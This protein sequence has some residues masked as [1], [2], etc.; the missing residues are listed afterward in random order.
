MLRS[1]SRVLLAIGVTA[2]I[3]SGT[4]VANASEFAVFIIAGQSNAVGY[5]SSADELPLEFQSPQTDILFWYEEGP[6]EAV[7]N[8]SL[9]IRSNGFV[10]LHYQTDSTGATFGGAIQ[11]FGAEISF[12]R[13]LADVLDDFPLIVDSIAIVKF[14]FNTASLAVDW[15]PDS[16]GSLYHQMI[17]Q[18]DL[19][20]AELQSRGHTAEIRGIWWMQGES[21]AQDSTHAT[22]YADNLNRLVCGLRWHSLREQMVA[23]VGRIPD[24]QS[25]SCCY[26][27]PHNQVVRSAQAGIEDSTTCAYW[28]N[29]DTL[30]LNSDS[31]HFTASSQLALGVE[32]ASAMEMCAFGF[33]DCFPCY[34][35]DVNDNWHLDV[36]DVVAAVNVAFR[37]QTSP[38]CWGYTLWPLTDHNC[39]GTTDVTDV[40]RT[41]NVA[42]RGMPWDPCNPCDCYP[43]P[44]NC[45]EVCKRNLP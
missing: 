15:H 31:V 41:I 35:G 28:V 12:G 4:S 2:C 44:D 45:P 11:G 25:P 17:A 27:I 21:D 38:G 14:A 20:I 34:M 30:P 7:Q 19:A 23:V 18:V 5:G 10:P 36:Q 3:F 42:F 26:A 32:A 43:Y 37:G 40:I 13:H 24:A 6:A 8:M 1:A 33:F 22:D 16:A 39:D 29:T 9:R